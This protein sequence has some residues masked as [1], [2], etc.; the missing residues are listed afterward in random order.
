MNLKNTIKI[1]QSEISNPEQ[2]LPYDLFLYVSSITPITNVDL[3]VKN[4]LNQ[5]L[6]SW[7]DDNFC[8]TGWHIPGRCIRVRETFAIAIQ[9]LIKTEIGIS[10]IIVNEKPLEINE[11]LFPKE[12]MHRKHFISILFEGFANSDISLNN[13]NKTETDIGYLKWFDKCPDN[14]IDCQELYRRFI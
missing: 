8:G 5:T 12:C 13:W 2:G 14:L 11:Y 7:R 4:E 3:L 1:L 9:K 10:S 6:L